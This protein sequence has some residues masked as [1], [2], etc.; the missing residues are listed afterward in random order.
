M[1]KI[2]FLLALLL[3]VLMGTALLTADSD[4][5]QSFS[6]LGLIATPNTPTVTPTGGVGT[7]WAYKIVAIRANGGNSQ[8]GSA[9]ST[10][11]G[12][13]TLDGT[14]FNVLTWVA[15]AGADG[16]YD[17]YRTTAGGTPNTTGKIGHV[18]AGVLTLKDDGLT[19]DASTAP[20]VQKIGSFGVFSVA[21]VMPTRHTIVL[22]TTGSPTGCKAHFN[23]GVDSTHAMQFAPDTGTFDC[24]TAAVTGFHVTDKPAVYGEIV[25]DE[26][27]G[28]SSPTIAPAYLGVH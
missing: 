2:R 7:T 8:A 13:A 20:T 3:L 1:K 27:S 11:A 12:A 23:G 22:V 17:V 21:T 10:A 6:A 4:I 18:A 14:H 19:G 5:T 15:S 24:S 9:G 26:L 28:G 25:V 16:G